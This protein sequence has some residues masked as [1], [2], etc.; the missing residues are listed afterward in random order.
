METDLQIPIKAPANNT[1]ECER[2]QYNV[3]ERD[4][5]ATGD[6]WYVEPQCTA[7]FCPYGKDDMD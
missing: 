5:Y 1:P 2:C 3:L 4:P 7:D 6:W